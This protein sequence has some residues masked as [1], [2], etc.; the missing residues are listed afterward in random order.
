M[1]KDPTFWIIGGVVGTVVGVIGA[2][3]FL[4]KEDW[5]LTA[6]FVLILIAGLALLG[7]AFSE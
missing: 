6:V 5:L 1:I 3:S 4:P 2:I 7:H